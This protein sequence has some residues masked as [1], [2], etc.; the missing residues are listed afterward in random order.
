MS[1]FSCFYYEI[2]DYFVN[3]YEVPKYLYYDIDDRFRS[4]NEVQATHRLMES[5][6]RA[7]YMFMKTPIFV[8]SRFKNCAD[9]YIPEHELTMIILGAESAKRFLF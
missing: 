8:K 2:N 3:E 7:W 9:E 5:S 4:F 6:S 1:D